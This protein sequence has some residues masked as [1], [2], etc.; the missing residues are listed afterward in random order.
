PT[1]S[2]VLTVALGTLSR[3][4]GATGNIVFDTAANKVTTAST[5]ITQSVTG[6]GSPTLITS[7]LGS[8]YLTF[9]TTAASIK[10]WAVIAAGTNQI[11]QAPSTGFYTPATSTT[12]SGHADIGTQ[13]TVTV[14]GAVGDN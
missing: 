2:N 4:S 11:V 10:D 13:T 12:I 7:A 9:G 14:A 8:A 5:Q 3:S 1:A 6:G